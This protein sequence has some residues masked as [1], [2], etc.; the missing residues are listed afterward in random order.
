MNSK[1]ARALILV[2]LLQA[3]SYYAIAFRDELVV[4]GAPLSTFPTKIQ[5]WDMI[6]DAPVEKEVQDILKA[7]DL[8]SRRYLNPDNRSEAYLFIAFFK[9][10]R[11][12][13]APHS[14]KNC[15]PGAGF[16]PIEDSRLPIQVPGWAA[17]I[18]VNKYV[19]ARG[20]EKSV[21][22]YW[23]QSHNRVIA[24][25]YWAKFW[26]VADAV[27]YRRSDTSLVK[28]VVPVSNNQ[29]DHATATGVNFVQSLFPSLLKQ[30]PL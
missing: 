10:Q 23:Y 28:I 19:T 8:L 18:V 20:D 14:P 15:L 5:S 21:T 22:L 1:Y 16:E 17:P 9:T 3:G 25:E 13:Q 2:L 7:D 26:L 27:R 30:L 11:Y 4:P 24:S 6:Q 12:G 29:V